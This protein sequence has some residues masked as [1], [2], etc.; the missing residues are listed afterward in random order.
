MNHNYKLASYKGQKNWMGDQVHPTDDLLDCS[1]TYN[2]Q[3]KRLRE[4]YDVLEAAGLIKEL[5]LLV[6]AARDHERNL[7]AQ[8]EAGADI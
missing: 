6:E 1:R 8:A 4:A 7:T 5:D 2:E 3:S